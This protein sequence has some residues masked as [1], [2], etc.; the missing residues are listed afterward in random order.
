MHSKK[1]IELL[2]QDGWVLSR[3]KGSHHIFTH[4]TKSG[5]ICIPHPK[6]DLGLGL[7]E[8]IL[9]YADLKKGS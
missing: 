2:K 7:V 6:K 8:K 3:T 9:K 4:K 1:L 5:H